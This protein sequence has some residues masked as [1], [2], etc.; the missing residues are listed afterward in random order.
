MSNT[1]SDACDILNEDP[2]FLVVG[3]PRG[4]FTLLL[5]I[6]SVFYR[7]L[8]LKKS[9]TQDIVNHFIPFVADYVDQE[10]LN[11]F[12]KHID[13]NDLFYSK[14]FKI[15]VGGPKWIED[16]ETICVRKYLGV[17]NKGDFTFIQYLPKFTME[18]D[19]VIHSHNHPGLWVESPYYKD[20]LK[21]ASIRNPIDIIHSSVYSINALT[22]EYIQRCIDEKD[23]DI[24]LE[25]ALNKLSNIE[26]MEGLV[27]YL[28]KYM[29]EFISVKNKYHH[30]MRWED[31]ITNPVK[32]ISEIARAGNLRFSEDYPLK[33]WQ[34][35][36]HRNLTRYHKH[37]FRKGLM[38][39]WKN[40][41]TNS[42]LELFKDYGFNDYLKEFGYDEIKYFKEDEYTHVQKTIEDH[43][44]RKE[45][46]TY[47]GDEDLYVFAFNKTNFSPT[48]SYRFKA[49]DRYGGIKI[50]KS[51]FRDESLL[52]G[53]IT[54]IGDAL[55]T[56]SSFLKDVHHQSVSFINGDHY[57]MNNVMDRYKETFKTNKHVF[58]KR[59][60][61][62]HNIWANDAIPILVGEY[63]AYNIVKIRKEHYAVPQSLGPM[64]LQ[65]VD[66]TKI[67]EIICC[68][69]IHDAYDKI[70]NH[71]R[72]TRGNHESQ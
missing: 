61:D 18:F 62:I 47:R 16:D 23:E 6:I 59:F 21:F 2:M 46:Y 70:D 20:Y 19:D 43:I 33:V 31:L 11:Y 38:H 42:H 12:Q 1:A 69:N 25:L 3:P 29:D 71:L 28:K 54:V 9:K 48:G 27:I 24:R 5:S 56:V 7:D 4:G 64:D 50:E 36:R 66:M 34:E 51:M 39:D 60:K 44:K 45:T 40:S 22:S 55:S 37:S 13:L 67:Q 58:D 8:G 65:T 63:K 10:M 68:K 32:T 41:I 57:G 14:E 49:Y 17:R 35:I 26:F 30:V 72:N 15:L 52:A 53:F